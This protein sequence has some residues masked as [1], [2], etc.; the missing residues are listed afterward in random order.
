MKTPVKI[1]LC[2]ACPPKRAADTEYLGQLGSLPLWHCRTCG[3]QFT[4]KAR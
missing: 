1:P 4:P 3:Y 2:P